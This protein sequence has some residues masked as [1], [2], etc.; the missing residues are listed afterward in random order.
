MRYVCTFFKLKEVSFLAAVFFFF[1]LLTACGTGSEKKE[2]YVLGFVNLNHKLDPIIS[3]LKE[4][5]EKWGYVEGQNVTYLYKGSLKSPEEIEP[6]LQRIITNG[7]DLLVALTT[8]VALK[9]KEVTAGTDI[10]VLFIPVF[11]PVESGIVQSL[12]SPEGNLTGIKV[13][14]STPKAL[15]WFQAALPNL[16]TIYVPFHHT[17]MTAIQTMADLQDA[18]R[19]LHLQLIVK[20]INN[21]AE[22]SAALSA[23][24]DSADAIWMTHSQLIVS[25]I[26]KFGKASLGR[27]LPVGSS[28]GTRNPGVLL[29]YSPEHQTLGEQA[30]RLAD[31]L[32]KK[33]P[34]ANIPVETAN[35]FLYL[36]LKSAKKLGITI[37]DSIISQADI[38]VR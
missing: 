20:N 18:A 36:N 33:V 4:N 12:A 31:K 23:I 26:E 34:V 25:N 22:L 9:A 8:P 13:R 2:H 27:E 7:V 29:S 28:V 30:S 14:G 6:E 38:V 35:F 11:S 37:P 21:E 5:L 19:K 15:E 24:P 10:P 32:L 1:S 17:S 3:S 16:K